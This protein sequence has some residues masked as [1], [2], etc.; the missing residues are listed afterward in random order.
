MAIIITGVEIGHRGIQAVEISQQR[1]A[2][3][4]LRLVDEVLD[5]TPISPQGLSLF[6]SEYKLHQERVVTSVPGDMLITR[7]ISVPF[8]E[9]SK[10][11]KIISYEMEPLVPFPIQELEI[12]YRILGQEK[13]G[14]NLMVYALP[15]TI[16]DQRTALFEEAGIPL[17]MVAVSSLSAAN[18]LFQIQ[19][20]KEQGSYFHFHVSS[21]FSILSIY[22]NSLLS[23]FQRLHWG[24]EAFL[25]KIQEITELTPGVLSQRLR[26]LTPK[27]TAELVEALKKQEFELTPHIRKILQAYLMKSQENPLNA[28]FIT[29]A[30]P[31]LKLLPPLLETGLSTRM[32]IPDPRSHFE[33]DLRNSSATSRMHAPLGMALMQAGKDALK[34]GF[35]KKRYSLLSRFSES[36]QEMRYAAIILLVLVLGFFVDFFIGLQAKDFHYKQLQKETRRVF[37]ETFP[38]VKNVRNELEQMKLKIVEIEK[39]N[40]IFKSVFGERPSSLDVLTELSTLIPEELELSIIDLTVDETSLR[41]VGWTDSFNSV[42]QIEQELKKSTLF[43]KASVSNAKVGKDKSRVNFQMKIVIKDS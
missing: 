8:R 20:I 9:T 25:E 26:E 43:E 24:E 23:H 42:N 12:C 2:V 3:R 22:E 29:G 34:C 30:V 14:S 21:N 5:G 38:D 6:F 7:Q 13:S 37:Q 40:D 35:R 4:M 33:H 17:S 39:Q 36:K 28:F 1:K 16:L 11:D 41:F 32:A 15:K 27:E 10:I 19:E 31:G 18:T